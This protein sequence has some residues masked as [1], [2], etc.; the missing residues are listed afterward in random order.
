[1]PGAQCVD[2]LAQ[3][4]GEREPDADRIQLAHL[5]RADQDEDEP[6]QAD[7]ERGPTRPVQPLLEQ[8]GR[9]H[10]DHGRVG[11]EHQQ[12]QADAD[13]GDGHQDGQVEERVGEAGE[14]VHQP[15]AARDLA[16]RTGH[17]LAESRQ[18]Q[19]HHDNDQPADDRAPGDEGQG[20]DAGGVRRSG[21]SGQ[22]SRSRPRPGRRAWHPGRRPSVAD[23]SRNGL[24]R[25]QLGGQLDPGGPSARPIG[26]GQHCVPRSAAERAPHRCTSPVLPAAG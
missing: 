25:L 8:H 9:H 15:L 26:P 19:R 7:H 6:D 3:A 22:G 18:D 24:G 16:E 20:V 23:R 2:H 11:V 13:S 4:A 10:R 14:N 5:A 1:M 17:D 21:T 12:G